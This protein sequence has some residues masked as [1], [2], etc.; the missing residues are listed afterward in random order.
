VERASVGTLSVTYNK[1]FFQKITTFH[2]D[3]NHNQ[4]Q[5]LL[6]DG[7]IGQNFGIDAVR[8]YLVDEYQHTNKKVLIFEGIAPYYV[9]GASSNFVNATTT[10]FDN[11]S[12]ESIISLGNATNG[13]T[14][15]GSICSLKLKTQTK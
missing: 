3:L 11:N 1:P 5:L 12:T 4:T 15:G 13:V 14:K 7:V 6:F 10:L 2:N 8:K 9:I